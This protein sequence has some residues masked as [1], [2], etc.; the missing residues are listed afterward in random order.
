MVY[1]IQNNQEIYAFVIG[2][3]SQPGAF[4]DKFDQSF[5]QLDIE[6]SC[7]FFTKEEAEQELVF[8][9]SFAEELILIPICCVYAG[10][11]FMHATYQNPSCWDVIMEEWLT[12]FD[13]KYVYGF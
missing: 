10:S 7:L 1:H 6:E 13:N 11:A 5:C 9:G 4:Y 2:K 8:Y 3:K 12:G